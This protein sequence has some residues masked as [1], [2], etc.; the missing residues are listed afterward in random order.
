[1]GVSDPYGIHVAQLLTEGGSY[2]VYGQRPE[3]A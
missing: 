1:M 3:N 2:F